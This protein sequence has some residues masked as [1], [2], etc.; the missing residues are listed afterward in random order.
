MLVLE[1][2]RNWANAMSTVENISCRCTLI[3]DYFFSASAVL[4]AMQ[5]GLFLHFIQNWGFAA[6]QIKPICQKKLGFNPELLHHCMETSVPMNLYTVY[7]VTKSD[8]C[9][10]RNETARPCSQF[11]HSWVCERFLY[12][13]DQSAYLAA[14]KKSRPLL[15]TY[16]SL[17]DA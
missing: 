5:L 2:F 17:T 9:I 16:K 13:Q 7:T 6:P 11:L 1:I 4:T 10:P 8:L 12:S 3:F 14:A 15:G